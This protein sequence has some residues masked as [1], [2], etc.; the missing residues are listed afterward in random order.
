M[1]LINVPDLSPSDDAFTCLETSKPVEWVRLSGLPSNALERNI[2]RIKLSRYRAA[3]QSAM[4]ARE[5]DVVISHHPL[6]SSAVAIALGVT[7]KNVRHIAWA[8]N[9]TAIP[10]SRRVAL[11]KKSLRGVEQFVVFSDFEK[12]FYSKTFEIDQEK[13]TN[14]LWTQNRPIVGDE[15]DF[16]VKD[17]FCAIGGEGRDIDLVIRAAERFSG[18]CNFVIITRPH[19]VPAHP[20]PSNVQILTNL[21]SKKTWAIAQKSLGVLI[22]LIS[23]ETCCGH[24]TIVSAKLLGIPIVTTH[25]F[26]TD[27]YVLGRESVLISKSGDVDEFSE[28]IGT[29]LDR[30]TDLRE[31]ARAAQNHETVLH[32]RKAWSDTLN[33]LVFR[34]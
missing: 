20:I 26:A 8:F 29:L 16:P 19:M 27:E 4:N 25:S 33:R 12:Q 15:F 7:R 34:P 21:P 18:I 14:V 6:M 10:S 9:F 1:R 2:K 3:A 5:G 32:S 28:R 17:Y 11:M 30:Q 13:F 24:I 23:N 22:P 31:A